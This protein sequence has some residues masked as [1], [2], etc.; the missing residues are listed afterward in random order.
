MLDKKP[1]LHFSG[2]VRSSKVLDLIYKVDDRIQTWT[3][4]DHFL[5][6]RQEI[7]QNESNVWGR[8]VVVFDPLT[9]LVKFYSNVTRKGRKTRETRREDPSTPHSQDIFGAMFFYRFAPDLNK[10][11]FP[12]HD[13]WKNWNLETQVIGRESLRTPAGEFETI[14]L[15]VFPRVEG[16]LK[17]QG[18]VELWVSDDPQR[19]MVQF[20]ARIRVGTVRGTLMEHRPGRRM[21]A[22]PPRLLTPLGDE[23]R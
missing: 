15:K 2:S 12:I 8:R 21:T 18:D 13:R 6:L 16:Q 20:R 7:E 10:L 5:P 3:S 4:L 23:L 9:H 17:P 1:V 14:H 11:R 22:P 19:I